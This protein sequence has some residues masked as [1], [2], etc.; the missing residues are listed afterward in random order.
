LKTNVVMSDRPKSV[1]FVAGFLFF[2]TVVAILVGSSLLFP[3][4]V[5]NSMWR[6]NRRGAAAFQALGNP[7]GYVLIGIG[8]ATCAAA[9]GLLRRQRWAWW[10]AVV[11]FAVEITGDAVMYSFT[12]EVLRAVAGVLISGMF[13]ALMLRAREWFGKDIDD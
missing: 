6:L 7:A 1:P 8:V 5:V 9:F 10:F 11:L 4:P 13:L 3:N 2:A 12:R